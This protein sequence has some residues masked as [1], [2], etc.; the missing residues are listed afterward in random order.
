MSTSWR[1]RRFWNW[2]KDWSSLFESILPKHVCEA[3][4]ATCRFVILGKNANGNEYGRGFRTFMQTYGE[5]PVGLVN[6]I[7]IRHHWIELDA[8]DSANLILGC[9]GLSV[10]D[11]YKAFGQPKEGEKMTV[12]LHDAVMACRVTEEI[13][14]LHQRRSI[15]V[16]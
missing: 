13:R 16:A 5:T 8:H 2:A 15:A 12:N 7:Q 10:D 11:V 1:P 6:D 9:F 14:P 3:A 4:M